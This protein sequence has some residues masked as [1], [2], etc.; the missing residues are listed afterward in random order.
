[1][2]LAGLWSMTALIIRCERIKLPVWIGGISFFFMINLIGV[3]SV[4]GTAQEQ[5]AYATA[6]AV[7]LLSRAFNGPVIGNTI[8]SISLTETFVFFSILVG[9]MSTLLVIRHTRANEEQG[10]TELV[11]SGVVGRYTPLMAS[12]IVTAGANIILGG[13]IAACYA[14]SGLEFEGSLLAGAA[15]ALVGIT[16]GSI[17]A[18]AAQ[19]TRSARGANGIAASAVGGMFLIRAIGDA[20]G[21]IQP[22][23]MDVISGPLSWLSPIGIARNA[24]PFVDNNWWLLLVLVVVSMF[25]SV[26]AF[27]LRS[28]RDLGAGFLPE[29]HGPARA[30]ATLL[31]Q[32]GLAWRLQRGLL[33]GWAIGLVILGATFGG[34][35]REVEAIGSGSTEVQ[36]VMTHLGG[37]RNLTEA[38]LSFSLLFTSF[39]VTAYLIQALLRLRTEEVNSHLEILLAGPTHRWAWALAHIACIAFGAA[40]LLVVSG[41]AAGLAYGAT[42]GDTWTQAGRLTIAAAAYLPVVLVFAGIVTCLYG[43]RLQWVAMTSWLLFVASFLII[44]FAELLQLPAWLHDLSPFAHAPHLLIDGTFIIQT[45]LI[46]LAFSVGLMG[47]GL[48]FL[49]RRDIVGQ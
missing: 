49:Q 47:I 25:V 42:I 28:R 34:V 14:A 13:I 23:G 1:M 29:R 38:Y 46:L 41:G 20:Q 8:A 21:T 44:Q 27:W 17:A 9:L 18:V 45:P 19:L 26:I 15:M 43:F 30:H 36:A 11:G 39:G 37:T 22:S 16:F 12:L 48:V 7:S 40:V 3:Q 32:L 2:N 10:L 35:S 31:S 33:L 24:R 6:S 4:Y 5:T